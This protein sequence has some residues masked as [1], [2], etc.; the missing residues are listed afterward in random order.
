LLKADQGA[1]HNVLVENNLFNGGGYT[2][3]WY[4]ANFQISQGIVRNNRFK[5]AAGGGYWPNG[6]Y[7]GPL[8]TQVSDN[9]RLPVWTNNVWDDNG[10]PINL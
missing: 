10:A 6:G 9:N 1:I 2:F 8:A 4:D 3:Y 5:R 7:Y